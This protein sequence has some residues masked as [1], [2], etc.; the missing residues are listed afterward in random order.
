MKPNAIVAISIFFCSI[1]LS[2]C[3]NIIPNTGADESAPAVEPAVIVLEENATPTPTETS[4]AVRST[5]TPEGPACLTPIAS[6]NNSSVYLREG[7]D[8][9]YQGTARYQKGD[10]FTL[11]GHQQDWFLSEAA[12]GNQGW[13]YKDWLT[14]PSDLDIE[15]VC[16]ASADNLP[17]LPAAQQTIPA[18]KEDNC[19][20][21]YYASCD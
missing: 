11:L 8:V 17:P 5:D 20:A 7:P 1:V 14:L 18:N 15:T 9:R 21:S 13:L 16:S 19:V 2:A 4:V 3:G 12:D 6:I 10:K